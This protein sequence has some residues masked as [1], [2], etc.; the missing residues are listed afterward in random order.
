[1]YQS[2]EGGSHAMQALTSPL[3]TILMVVVL[4]AGFMMLIVALV[5]ELTA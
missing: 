4:L 1:M 2:E 5:L 3:L